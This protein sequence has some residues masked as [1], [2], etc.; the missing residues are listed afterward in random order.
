MSLGYQRGN[1]WIRDIRYERC[2]EWDAY[3]ALIRACRDAGFYFSC[4]YSYSAKRYETEIISLSQINGRW[5]EIKHGNAFHEH[6][7]L[8]IV[9]AMRRHPTKTPLTMAVCLELE[10]MVL[11]EKLLLWSNMLGGAMDDLGRSIREKCL[12]RA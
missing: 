12:E 8:S 1:M 7:M 4:R 3:K 11:R 10:V 6:P 9:Y 2:S 5:Y